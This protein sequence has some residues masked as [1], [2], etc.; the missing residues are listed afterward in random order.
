MMN[1]KTNGKRAQSA[2]EYL[3]TYGWAILI[4]AVVLGA[5]YVLGV[6]NGTS[7]LGTSCVAG[8]GYQCTNLLLHGGYLTFTFGQATGNTWSNVILYAVPSGKAFSTSD[9]NTG[10]GV[11]LASGSTMSANIPTA[12]TTVGGS[13]S[14]YIYAQYTQGGITGLEA[15]VATVTAKAT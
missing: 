14:G 11:S 5:L 10:A 2:M 4:I 9:N 3:M 13:W 7:F 12:I 15:Q 1:S 6:F 8:S